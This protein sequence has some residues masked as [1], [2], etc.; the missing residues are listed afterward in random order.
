MGSN[1]PQ[2]CFYIKLP[3][4]SASLTSPMS[5]RMRTT[6][7]QAKRDVRLQIWYY[8]GRDFLSTEPGKGSVKHADEE[9]TDGLAIQSTAQRCYDTP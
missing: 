4:I 3:I 2:A 5:V 9:T 6:R 7:G 8:S 1:P